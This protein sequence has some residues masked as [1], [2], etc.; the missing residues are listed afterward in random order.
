MRKPKL[1][2]KEVERV[3]NEIRSYNS[4]PKIRFSERGGTYIHP[5]DLIDVSP[6]EPPE[7]ESLEVPRNG[8]NGRNGSNGGPKHDLT[9]TTGAR[10][11]AAS[12]TI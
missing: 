9:S 12:S 10:A 11:K 5:F 4:K 1:S 7:E 3:L 8:D 2:D 6:E